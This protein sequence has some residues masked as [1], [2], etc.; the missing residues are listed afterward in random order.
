[1]KKILLTNIGGLSNKGI[2]MMLEAI[3]SNI[4]AK[5]YYHKLTVCKGY[6]SYGITGTWKLSGFDI[7]LDLGGDTFTKYYGFIQFIRHTLHLLLLVIFNQPYALFSQTFSPYGF[8]SSRIAKYFMR[9][10]TFITVREKRSKDLLETMGISSTLTGDLAFL[11]HNHTASFDY[12][13]GSY[14]KIISALLSG[15][16]GVWDNSRSNNFKFDIFKEKL[17]LDE[18]RRKAWINV[19]ML[20][21]F[22]T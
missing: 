11:L 3:I 19:E 15:L 8:F 6:E 22:L 1:M 16:S 2:R 14:H 10:A 4:P 17:D 7:A 21:R 18:M 20:Q 5:F 12:I 9:R 13:G